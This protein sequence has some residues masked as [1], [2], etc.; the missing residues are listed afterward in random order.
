ML[1]FI[2]PS[3]VNELNS[4]EGTGERGEGEGKE[5]WRGE[6]PRSRASPIFEPVVPPHLPLPPLSRDHFSRDDA[7][8]VDRT[9]GLLFIYLFFF[10][11]P[12][13]IR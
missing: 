3:F 13:I 9:P 12:R 2:K 6:A 11:R 1:L 8:T 5:E 10:F 7:S 4:G